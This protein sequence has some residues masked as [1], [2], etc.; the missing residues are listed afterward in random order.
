MQRQRR[1]IQV[2]QGAVNFA[3]TVPGFSGNATIG[4]VTEVYSDRLTCDIEMYDGGVLR[5][6]PVC[7]KAGLQDGEVYGTV[8][9][10]AIDDYVIIDFA[11]GST[12]TKMIVG[13]IVPYLV[14]EFV[15][16]AVNSGSKAHTKKLLEKGKEKTYKKIFK[17]GTTIE[18]GDDGTIIVETPSGAYIMIDEDAGEVSIV[19]ANGNDI[20][21][22]SSSVTVNGGNLEVLQ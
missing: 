8:D 15:K 17:S 20:T 2:H 22:G 11:S 12:R 10:P 5:N 18:V 19:D 4:K 21:M 1:N 6:I 16:D 14:N 3:K 9:L 7:T 13:T